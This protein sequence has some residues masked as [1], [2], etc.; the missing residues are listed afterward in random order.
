M[1][2][3]AAAGV[4]APQSGWYA[5]NPLLGPTTLTDLACAGP[6]CY[7]SGGFG[8]LLKSTDSGSSWNGIVT[9]LTQDLAEVRLIAG[10]PSKVITGGGCALRRSDN[11]GETFNRL[12]FTASDLSCPSPVA[13][14][15]FPNSNEGYIALAD[16]SVYFTSD[17]GQSFSRRTAI[18]GVDP[19]REATDIRCPSPTTCFAVSRAGTVQRT[20]D[21]GNSWTQVSQPGAPLNAIFFADATTG[22]AVGTALRVLKTTDGGETWE[23]KEVVGTPGGDLISVRCT[24]AQLCLFSTAQGGQVIRTTDGGE[25]W[26]SVVTS[27]DP[28]YAVDFSS[29]TRAV[30]VGASG[31]ASVSDDAGSTWKSIGSRLPGTYRIIRGVS[32]TVA[33]AGGPQGVLARTIDAGQSWKNVSPPTSAEIVDVG[34][35]DETTIFVLDSSGGLQR[36][37]NGGASYSILDPGAVANPIRVVALGA[38]R[39]VLVGRRGVG[40]S[41]DNGNQFGPVRVPLRQGESLVSVDLAAG[42]LVARAARGLL[43]SANGGD[44]WSRMRLPRL[45]RS[46][47][48]SDA[49]FVSA[50]SGFVRLNSGEVWKTGSGGRRWV[51]VLSM[52]N[53]VVFRDMAFSDARNGYVAGAMFG[54]TLGIGRQ[55]F[56]GAVLRTSDGGATWRPQIVSPSEVR[57][58]SSGGSTDYALAGDGFLYGTRTGGDVGAPSK[59][60]LRSSARRVKRG[61]TVRVAG[62]LTPADGGERV[63]VFQ[64]AGGIWRRQEVTVAANGSFTTRWRMRRAALFV[65]QV[66][67]D[68]DHAGTGTRPIFVTVP[69]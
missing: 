61:R 10:D 36:S 27:T 54:G 56:I 57:A 22:Y 15:S 1:A 53:L 9:G 62:V 35:P 67:G 33:F 49:D 7:A 30:A 17:G 66:L 63:A 16:G 42:V 60:T 4:I 34:A 45:S 48:V 13:S 68:A 23:P 37:T 8:T 40:V 32:P 41:T 20:T 2:A 46:E 6:T 24:N 26:S 52:G 11:G 12:P 29:E 50:R 31:S 21:S 28:T 14:F 39:V 59:L 69:R 51:E 18:P 44:T 58:V 43:V 19:S 5:G 38:N 25:T 65:A 64:R 55:T 47:R 3:P